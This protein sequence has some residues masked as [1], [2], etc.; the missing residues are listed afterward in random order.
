MLCPEKEELSS[1]FTTLS[2]DNFDTDFIVAV[3]EDNVPFMSLLSNP[4][5]SMD[6]I[7]NLHYTDNFSHV[8]GASL[9]WQIYISAYSYTI[10]TA[11]LPLVLLPEQLQNKCYISCVL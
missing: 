8:R 5:F 1:L 6:R 11:S 3:N 9:Q 7:L 4:D 10:I 2:S